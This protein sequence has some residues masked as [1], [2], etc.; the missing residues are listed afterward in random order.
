MVLLRI[1][2]IFSILVSSNGD[3]GSIQASVGV[4]NSEG[5]NWAETIKSKN[6]FG[7]LSRRVRATLERVKK[8]FYGA[9]NFPFTYPAIQQF[10]NRWMNYKGFNWID[11][12]TR[13]KHLLIYRCPLVTVYFEMQR[14]WL[15][16]SVSGCPLVMRDMMLVLDC[17]I[18][19][20]VFPRQVRSS[21]VLM[22]NVKES[23]CTTSAGIVRKRAML[24]LGILLLSFFFLPFRTQVPVSLT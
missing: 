21:V 3:N 11:H 10:C 19:K 4:D 2:L 24:W 23:E 18:T 1:W 8:F 17:A 15:A 12:S 20:L 9:K 16:A 7:F 13:V 22:D 5:I 14:T 6:Q